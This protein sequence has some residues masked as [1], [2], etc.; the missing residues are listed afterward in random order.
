MHLVYLKVGTY[1]CRQILCLC[2]VVII[3][4]FWLYFDSILCNMAKRKKELNFDYF[5]RV[6]YHLKDLILSIWILSI[7]VWYWKQLEN[8]QEMKDSRFMKWKNC[9][10]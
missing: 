9:I 5:N 10:N 3:V 1:F 2:F 7:P 6:V 8:K 4:L